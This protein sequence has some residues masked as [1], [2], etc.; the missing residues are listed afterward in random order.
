[1]A[2][3]ET[4]FLGQKLTPTEKE[5]FDLYDRLR[6]LVQREDLTPCVRSN[7]RFATATLA[8]LVNDLNLEWEHLYDHGV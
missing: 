7:L 8:Q 4:D 5:I 6:S 3:P 2:T 1:M